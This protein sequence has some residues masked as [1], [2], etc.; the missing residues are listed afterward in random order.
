MAIVRICK[1]LY[2]IDLI[3]SDNAPHFVDIYDGNPPGTF[4][5]PPLEIDMEPE[6]VATIKEEIY[7]LLSG[8]VDGSHSDVSKNLMMHL[9]PLCLLRDMFKVIIFKLIHD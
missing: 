3:Y 9:N 6:Q 8:L 7:F 1:L 2:D 4:V 5:P